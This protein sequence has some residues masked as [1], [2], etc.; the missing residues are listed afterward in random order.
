M[1]KNWGYQRKGW[2][3]RIT[4]LDF[5][6]ENLGSNMFLWSGLLHYSLRVFAQSIRLRKFVRTPKSVMDIYNTETREEYWKEDP[7][8]LSWEDL[9]YHDPQTQ[10]L[11][12]LNDRIVKGTPAQTR[13]FMLNALE[14]RIKQYLYDAPSGMRYVVE[15]GCGTGR[16][17]LYLKRRLP[18]VD[19]IGLE[20]TP[21]NV[22]LARAAAHKWD[23]DVQFYQSDV[24]AELP[25]NL[26]RTI[27]ISFSYLA[28]EQMPRIFPNVV[29]QMVSLAN[30]AVLLYEPCYEMYP[31]N[32]RGIVSKLRIIYSDYIRGLPHYLKMKGYKIDVA[33]RLGTAV[34]PFNEPCE[35]V[36][37]TQKSSGSRGIL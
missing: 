8:D 26:P 36:L 14:E 29:E 11:I 6:T 5:V 24:S 31:L 18:D 19:F 21:K 23:I 4:H 12:L 34:N 30:R 16:N 2:G 15:F 9:V 35:I 25:P 3:Y 37:D 13:H 28:L 17:I 22:D 32:M 27:A 1:R 20:L 7:S 10:A 33:R